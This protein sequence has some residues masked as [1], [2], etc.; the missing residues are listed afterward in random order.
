MKKRILVLTTVFL[1]SL[2]ATFA[3]D[4]NNIP[5]SIVKALNNEFQNIS[6]DSLQAYFSDGITEEIITPLSKIADL[7][8]ISRTSVIF[9][10]LLSRSDHSHKDGRQDL[11]IVSL[12]VFRPAMRR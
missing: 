2:S 11:N 8:V 4:T 10:S 3:I 7:K 6:N 1:M 9:Y 12:F 5:E